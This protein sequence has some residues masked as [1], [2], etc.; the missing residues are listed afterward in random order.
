LENSL[1]VEV[2]VAD[3]EKYK[4]LLT[5][6]RAAVDDLKET[7]KSLEFTS[8]RLVATGSTCEGAARALRQVAHNIES[9]L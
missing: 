1:K 9:A 3:L 2:N 7:A 5:V 8:R 6:L 4:T